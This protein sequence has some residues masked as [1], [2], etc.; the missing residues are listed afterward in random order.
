[1]GFSKALGSKTAEK[2]HQR[3]EKF[4]HQ[5]GLRSTAGDGTK[6][7]IFAN[8]VQ[9]VKPQTMAGHD[10]ASGS[11]YTWQDQEVRTFDGSYRLIASDV[12]NEEIAAVRKNEEAL[13]DL[14][15]LFLK[16][17]SDTLA[18]KYMGGFFE[19]LPQNGG[20]GD[21]L[22]RFLTAANVPRAGEVSQDLRTVEARPSYLRY[23]SELS[24]D[25]G[26]GVQKLKTLL[27]LCGFVFDNRKL[28]REPD[29]LK[30]EP[31]AVAPPGGNAVA[32]N[33]LVDA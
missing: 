2:G 26:R 3:H 22:T 24:D 12:M 31:K 1:M 9:V 11:Y 17:G 20:D 29:G 27:S 18:K 4:R 16:S 7:D 5:G 30:G 25:F 19:F 6:T 32:V 15:E 23:K 33:E 28:V 14:V 8:G 21:N 13:L 10:L